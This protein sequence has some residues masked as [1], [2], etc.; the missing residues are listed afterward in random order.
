MAV[1]VL[2]GVE[3]G[4]AVGIPVPVAVAVAVAVGVPVT[5]GRVNDIEQAGLAASGLLDGTFGAT[6][7]YRD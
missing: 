7:I 2:V 1:A 3:V 6:E 4:V 5:V